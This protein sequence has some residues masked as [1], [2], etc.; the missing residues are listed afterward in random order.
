[1]TEAQRLD[2]WLWFA[3]FFKSRTLAARLCAGHKVRINRNIVTKASAT[4]KVGDVLTFPQGHQIRVVR[5]VDLGVRRGP[6]SEAQA[7]YEDLAPPSET[8]QPE[9]AA[10]AE[11]PRG[12][13]RPTKRERR[14]LD[15]LRSAAE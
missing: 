3:R 15:R 14:D 10:P 1:M 11:R 2:R 7:L 13:G 8:K 9:D 12:S 6:A 4:V 5:V